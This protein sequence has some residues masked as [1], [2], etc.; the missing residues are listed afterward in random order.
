[1]GQHRRC[2]LDY[3]IFHCERGKQATF[4][5]YIHLVACHCLVNSNFFAPNMSYPLVDYCSDEQQFDAAML[6][7]IA[8]HAAAEGSEQ[9]ESK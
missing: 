5:E 2:V 4:E 7:N 3:A 8:A 6:G 1:M 9:S